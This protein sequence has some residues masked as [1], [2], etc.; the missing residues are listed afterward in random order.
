MA[1]AQGQ[2]AEGSVYKDFKT[3]KWLVSWI[4]VLDVRA[5]QQRAKRTPLLPPSQEE[6]QQAVYIR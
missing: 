5:L 4:P 3:S 2:S 6:D 1:E